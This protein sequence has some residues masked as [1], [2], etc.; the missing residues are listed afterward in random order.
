MMNL[1]QEFVRWE[2]WKW[3]RR[4][5]KKKTQC[6]QSDTG[7]VQDWAFHKAGDEAGFCVVQVS[8]YLLSAYY[9]LALS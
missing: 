3:D 1:K 8:Y 5:I 9:V 4:R 6:I 7:Q 2:E